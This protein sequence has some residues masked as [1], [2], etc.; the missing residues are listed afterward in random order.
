MFRSLPK[1][2]FEKILKHLVT[3][4]NEKDYILNVCFPLYK[5]RE[6]MRML[7][8]E[9]IL[10]VNDLIS[11]IKIYERAKEEAVG[12]DE[13]FKGIMLPFVMVGSEVSVMDLDQDKKLVYRVQHP[14]KT[15]GSKEEISYVSPLGAALLL[16]EPGQEVVIKIPAGKLRY[17]VESIRLASEEE[18]GT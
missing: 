17:R 18:G 1:V 7:L 5:E 13:M 15:N 4:E 12:L 10:R 14:F 2:A 8:D 11:R 16:K 6:E 3:V 9:Y